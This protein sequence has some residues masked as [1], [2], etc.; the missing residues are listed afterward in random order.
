MLSFVMKW[1]ENEMKVDDSNVGY[2][3][4]DNSLSI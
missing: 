2:G 1:G 3:S 4:M